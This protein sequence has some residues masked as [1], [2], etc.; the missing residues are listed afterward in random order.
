MWDHIATSFDDSHPGDHVNIEVQSA[1]NSYWPKVL[2]ALSSS[3][4][5]DLFWSL[6]G[7]RMQSY[8]QAGKAQPFADAGS[9][10]AG[11]P[12]WKKG[13]TDE[14]AEGASSAWPLRTLSGCRPI[15]L[16]H[17]RPMYDDASRREIAAFLSK[18]LDYVAP[19]PGGAATTPPR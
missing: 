18:T 3:N 9:N 19:W 13:E 1:L 7:G 11:N 12:S 6:G 14:T 5:P 4:P 2:D 17:R 16:L 10:D 8:I 15:G